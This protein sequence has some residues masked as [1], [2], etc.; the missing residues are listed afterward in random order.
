MAEFCRECSEK[1]GFEFDGFYEGEICEQCG[2][3]KKKN[4]SIFSRIIKFLKKN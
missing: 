2:I 1:S 4:L 3:V